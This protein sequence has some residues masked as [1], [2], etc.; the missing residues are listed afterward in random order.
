MYSGRPSDAPVVSQRVA[1]AHAQ[2]RPRTAVAPPGDPPAALCRQTCRAGA[3][4]VQGR[5]RTCACTS[6]EMHHPTEPSAL[7]CNRRVTAARAWP[8]PTLRLLRHMHAA[9]PATRWHGAVDLPQ[10]KRLSCGSSP[11]ACLDGCTSYGPGPCHLSP[12]QPPP[13]HLVVDPAQLWRDQHAPPPALAH[14]QH[15]GRHSRWRRQWV[16]KPAGGR[17]GG[18]RV[19]QK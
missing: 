3:P 7:P 2:A 15:G 9:R 12:L 11:L 8:I 14:T 16:A 17:A 19:R 4:P 10:A 1:A 5:P 18:G 13:P 6:R